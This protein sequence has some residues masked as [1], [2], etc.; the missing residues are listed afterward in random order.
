MT[1][2][3]IAKEILVAAIE[4]GVFST[5]NISG[6]SS[7]ASNNKTNSEEL[8]KMY[9]AIYKSVNEAMMGDY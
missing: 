2:A 7:V 9:K 5:Y 8:S 6:E 1:T 4:K 3:E